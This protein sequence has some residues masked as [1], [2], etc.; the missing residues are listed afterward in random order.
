MRVG[1]LKNQREHHTIL[2][3]SEATHPTVVSE[4]HS[5]SWMLLIKT[6]TRIVCT[7]SNTFNLLAN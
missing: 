5:S 3:K 7:L 1:G 2:T 6:K 4:N